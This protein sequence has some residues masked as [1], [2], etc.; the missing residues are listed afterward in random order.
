MI[1]R[2]KL[3]DELESWQN[4]LGDSPQEDFVNVILKAVIDKVKVQ[5]NI[6]EEKE[7][8]WIPLAERLPEYEYDTVLCVTSKNHYAVYVYT[9]EHGF[10]TGD[11][12]AEGEVVAWMSLPESYKPETEQQPEQTAPWKE[13]VMRTFLGGR[14]E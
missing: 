11:I 5:P 6:P 13:A 9:S 7:V 14:L 8:D 4:R 2:Q 10:R 12:D 1:D 3:I